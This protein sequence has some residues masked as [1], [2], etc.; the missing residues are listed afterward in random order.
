MFHCKLNLAV[1]IIFQ[2]P[3]PFSKPISILGVFALGALLSGLYHEQRFINLEIR[4]N[5]K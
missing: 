3:S 2:H 1:W 5:T 4:Y